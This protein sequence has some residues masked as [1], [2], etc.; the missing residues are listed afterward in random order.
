MLL[1]QLGFD[2]VGFDGI[3]GSWT[4]K[5]YIILLPAAIAR[6]NESD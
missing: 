1:Q 3:Y 5:H 4:G 2:A 6:K